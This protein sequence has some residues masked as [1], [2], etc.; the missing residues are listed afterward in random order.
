VVAHRA[1]WRALGG[2][3]LSGLVAAGCAIPTQKSPSAIP[4]GRVPPG[5]ESPATSST[6]TTQ[7]KVSSEVEVKIFLVGPRGALVP[8]SRVVEVPAPL[9]SIITS[10]LAGP[11]QTESG[12]GITTAIPNNVQLLSAKRVGGVVTVN[13][14]LAFGQITGSATELAVAQVVA[15]VVTQI[16]NSTGVV[17]EIEGEAISVPIASGAQVPGPVYL[18]QFLNGTG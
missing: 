18:L 8:R 3:A 4:A 5:L 16:G 13:F 10:M 17:F 1:A 11:D 14:N 15:T 7:P 2:V 12:L 6:T 9:S